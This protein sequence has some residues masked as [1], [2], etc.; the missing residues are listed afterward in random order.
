MKR[1]VV[2]GYY[3]LGNV[4]DEAVL[5]GMLA[6]FRALDENVEFT[7]LSGDPAATTSVHGVKAINRYSGPAVFREIK[8][9][10]LLISGGGSLLQDVT[11]AR[12]AAYYFGVIFLAQRLRT[13]VMIYAQ[14]IGPL[15]RQSSKIQAR[16]LLNRARVITVRDSDS[17]ALLKSMGVTKPPVHVTADPSFA[18]EPS[19]QEEA[20]HILREAGVEQGK[21]LLGVAAR[22]WRTRPDLP[23]M[24]A[25]ALRGAC[26]SLDAAPLFLPMSGGMDIEFAQHVAAN[27]GMRSHVLAQPLL[28][29]QAKAVSRAVEVMFAMRLH[30][31]MFAASQE[32]P[33]VALS[34]DPKVTAFAATM[35]GAPALDVNTADAGII[36]EAIQQ[37]WSRRQE[38][39]IGL[40][41]G[42]PEWRR[43]A[44]RNAHLA[45]ES[46]GMES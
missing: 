32:T 41:A 13:P 44:V 25:E 7:V 29:Q 28:P 9:A 22:S 12:S 20:A 31:L 26:A 16:L 11:S 38:I 6:S 33:T 45:L 46:L 23:N 21:P 40:A 4:G 43:E 18:M 34:Y 10:D 8:A 5:A 42:L 35:P 3:G 36:S 17:A 24:L 39:A 14:G 15:T 19:D 1:I 27:M 2:S 37:T 30:A